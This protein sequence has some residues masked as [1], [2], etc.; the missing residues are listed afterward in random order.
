MPCFLCQRRTLFSSRYARQRCRTHPI[1]SPHTSSLRHLLPKYL[2]TP[3]ILSI[4][5]FTILIQ[6]SLISHLDYCSHLLTRFELLVT[7]S[8]FTYIYSCFLPIISP[9]CNDMDLLTKQSLS[10][11]P[12]SGLKHFNRSPAFL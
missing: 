1:F 11:P 9:D 12:H 6:S 5:V 2:S 7:Y 8:C 3:S 4:S 10:S